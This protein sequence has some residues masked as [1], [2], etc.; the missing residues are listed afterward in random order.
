MEFGEAVWAK[1]RASWRFDKDQPSGPAARAVAAIWVGVCERTGENVV[2]T[3]D[4]SRAA[5]RVRTVTRRPAQERWDKGGIL[6]T[7]ATPRIPDPS[8]PGRRDIPTPKQA[9]VTEA[10][11][12]YNCDGEAIPDDEFDDEDEDDQD[13]AQDPLDGT[14]AAPIGKSSYAR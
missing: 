11:T 9:K 7:V 5:I 2:L 4:G 3:L 8:T 10:R 13:V 6:G 1:P 12:M 14:R